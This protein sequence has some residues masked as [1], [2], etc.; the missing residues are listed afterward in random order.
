MKLPVTD[1]DL[2]L[3]LDDTCL[4]F[5]NENVTFIEKHVNVD[6]NSLCEW[7]IDNRLSIHWGGD[8]TKCILY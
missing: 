8:K 4:L 6:F 5:S 7:F 2:R 3:Y 1:C